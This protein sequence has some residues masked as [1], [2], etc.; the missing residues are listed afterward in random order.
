MTR[1]FSPAFHAALA[2]VL[3]QEG[4]WSDHK[5][6]PG[7]ATMKGITLGVFRQWRRNNALTKR[8]LR[9]ISMQ[10]VYEIY[11]DL[12]WRNVRGDELKPSAALLMMDAAVNSGP[13]QAI[14]CLQRTLKTK[15]PFPI[16]PD[17][18]LGPQ[19]LKAA[20]AVDEIHLIDEFAARRMWFYGML[21]KTFLHFGLGWSRRLMAAKRAADALVAGAGLAAQVLEF[22]TDQPERKT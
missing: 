6:D 12:Y 22:L 15:T 10:E 3:Q 21:I 4:G 5:A 16:A 11:H 17:G 20:N 8:D 9:E 2:H 18:V 13:K 14:L 19:T 1:T 7:G